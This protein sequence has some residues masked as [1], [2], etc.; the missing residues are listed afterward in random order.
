MMIENRVNEE[1][2]LPA[3]SGLYADSRY[4][5]LGCSTQVQLIYRN[6]TGT[7]RQ[8]VQ[9]T[10]ITVPACDC[11]RVL[12]QSFVEDTTIPHRSAADY[13]SLLASQSR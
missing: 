10:S 6:L 5:T 13:Y 2:A 9:I 1:A 4:L 7:A 11:T 8:L 3:R 12:F